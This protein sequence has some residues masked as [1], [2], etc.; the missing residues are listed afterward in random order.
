MAKRM[1]RRRNRAWSS[2]DV[3]SLRGFAKARLS[4]PEIAK[5]LKRT[6]GAVGQKAM[7]LGIRFRSLR[8]K[9]K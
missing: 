3:R 2:E 4:G 6:T 5:K 8:R 9:G 1:K 7:N